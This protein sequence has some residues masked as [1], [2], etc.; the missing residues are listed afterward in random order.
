MT[1]QKNPLLRHLWNYGVITVSCA[2]YALAFNCFFQPN[3]IAM[4]G[5]TGIA[6]IL[7]LFLPALPVGT[8]VLV[9]NVPLL[10]VAARKQGAKLLVGTLY[11][12]AVSSLM[13]DAMALAYTFPPMEPLLACIFGGLLMG[14]SLGFV[15]QQGATTGGTDLAARLL[16]LV[17]KWLPMGKLLLAVD[18]IVVV[19]VALSFQTINTALYGL[20]ALYISTLA[21]DGVLY[22]MDTAKV[23]YIISEKAHEIS[24]S[25][26][27]QMDRGVTVLPGK[28]AYSGENK[29]VLMCAFKQKEIVNLKEIIF[30]IDPKAFIIV[31]DAHEVTGNG[32]KTYQKNDI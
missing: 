21:L 12:I 27:G 32:F 1:R 3:N 4:G 11:A 5:F 24:D 8:T 2:I 23:A 30:E 28:G 22:G 19:S 10:A 26:V 18:L 14:L 13:I 6:Q 25:I 31:C 15:F 16:K 20:V 29:L 7:N 9:M 17:F